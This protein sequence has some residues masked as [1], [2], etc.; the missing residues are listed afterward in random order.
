M[1]QSFPFTTQL[2]IIGPVQNGHNPDPV[3]N[4]EAVQEKGVSN[5]GVVINDAPIGT[6]TSF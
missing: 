1:R 2:N 4:G 3:K 5:P 6:D